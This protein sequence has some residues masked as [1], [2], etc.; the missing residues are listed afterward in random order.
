[1]KTTSVLIAIILFAAIS[2]PVNGQPTAPGPEGPPLSLKQ[3]IQTALEKHPSLQS[4]EFAVRGADARAKQAE[5]KCV[6]PIARGVGSGSTLEALR[7]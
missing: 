5:R 7:I 1:M 3:A 2:E 4:A 6:P